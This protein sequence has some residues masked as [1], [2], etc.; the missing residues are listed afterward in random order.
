MD[1]AIEF[2][3]V[4]DIYDE[5]VRT[6][7]DVPFF[8][9]ETRKASGEVLELMCGTGRLSI[10]LLE[11]G[12]PLVCVDYSPEMLAVLRGKIEDRGFAAAVHAMDVRELDLGRRFEL[13][14]LP[15]NSFSELLT[16]DDQRR[17]LRSIH[18][19]LAAGGRFICTLHN[20]AVRLKRVDGQLRLWGKYKRPNGMLL[21]W[22]WEQ[23]DPA[24]K[25]VEG[26]ELFEE[27]DEQGRQYAKRAMELRF[28]IVE[29]KEFEAMAEEAGFTVEALYGDYERAPFDEERS[30]F[31]IWELSATRSTPRA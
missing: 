4:A 10:P 28:R 26:L 5:F 11:A 8:L 2:A 3:R 18:D 19:H 30:P 7:L 6:E 13:I 1:Q 22:G 12:V 21:F 31:M 23:Y 24:A 20:P 17:A 16:E 9:S 29:R 25:R 27:Y 14:I 15:F